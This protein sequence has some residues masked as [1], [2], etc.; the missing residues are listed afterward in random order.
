MEK[1]KT[2]SNTI[3]HYV[4]AVLFSFITIG[5]TTVLFKNVYVVIFTALFLLVIVLGVGRLY[6]FKKDITSK[7]V[8]IFFI[9][10]ISVMFILQLVAGYCLQSTPI[11]DWYTLDVIAKN[12]AQ[13]GNFTNMYNGLPTDRYNYMARYTNNNG[14]LIL[15]SLYYRVI[16]LAF[17][18]VPGF[19]PVVL[20]TI[21]ITTSV[22]FTFL[23]SKRLFKPIGVLFTAVACFLFAPFYTY[24]AYYYSDS[25]SIPFTTISIYLI[26]LG[27]QTAQE[28][29]SKKILFLVLAG[30]STAVGYT[31][32]GSI[33]VILVGA[34]VYII[35]AH[36]LK[37]TVISIVSIVLAFVIFMSG[38][39]M[40]INSFNFVT[41]EELYEEQYPINHWIMMGLNGNGSFNL[42][43]A[44]AT[45]KA[46][47]Y[48]EKKEY[49]NKEIV[50]RIGDMGIEGMVEHL[51]H[52]SSFTWSDGTYWINYHLNS[53]DADG[54]EI[55]NRNPLF[56]FVLKDGKYIGLF[57]AYSNAFH[58]CMLFMMI[59]SAYFMAKKKQITEMTL[60]HGV[61]FG[62]ALF[63]LIW[64]T[65]SRY[66]YNFTPLFLL[67]GV[68]GATLL[69]DNVNLPKLKLNFRKPKHQKH[70]T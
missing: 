12:F 19:A 52:K 65:R 43:D 61:I 24:T 26:I 20:N 31:I 10:M 36:K 1:L 50:K 34:I 37:E 54:N 9:V 23:I 62:V 70:K 41:E 8:N 49:A 48:D 64:E 63:F 32:K 68:N 59:V 25:L 7:Q 6:E 33:L 51:Y 3:F 46:G 44:S 17:G 28:K 69:F 39:N 58:V 47:N 30:L 4:Y 53:K 45:R 18:Y 15:L 16:Y 5:A 2:Q 57:S 35:L 60:I 56:E 13:D 27:V 29:L 22:V 38:I 55:E 42:K 21:F 11:T 66:L 40:F 67:A 14:V